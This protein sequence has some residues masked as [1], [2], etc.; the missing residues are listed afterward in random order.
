M[1]R[2]KTRNYKMTTSTELDYMRVIKIGVGVLLVVGIV[3][4]VTA[5][6]SGEIKL[7]DKKKEKAETVIQYEEILAGETFN[8]KS[9]SYY[10]V[11]MDFTD[12]YASYFLQS[13]AN[14]K[15]TNNNYPFYTV[16]LE[17][18][19]NKD[20]A[21]NELKVSNPTILKITNGAIEETITGK[22]D[23]VKFFNN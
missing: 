10:V 19:I 1:K 3:Y 8:R 2:N 7:G 18:K 17:K 13:I 12:N 14:F 15:A 6:A 11:Y 20:Y 16:D 22:D 5:L 9:N 21:T 4:L 23:V